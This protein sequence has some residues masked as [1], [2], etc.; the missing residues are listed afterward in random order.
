M[1]AAGFHSAQVVASTSGSDAPVSV[2]TGK[3]KVAFET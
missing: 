3:S 1:F 2:V